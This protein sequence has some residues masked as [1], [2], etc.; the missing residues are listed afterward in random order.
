MWQDADGRVT[1][2]YVDEI[3]NVDAVLLNATAAL[4]TPI[5]ATEWLALFTAI[6]PDS[7]GVVRVLRGMDPTEDDSRWAERQAPRA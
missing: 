6:V 7:D 1:S 2:T 3:E 5:V 4:W